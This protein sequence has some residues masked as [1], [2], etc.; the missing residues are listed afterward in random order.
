MARRLTPWLALAACLLATACGPGARYTMR[1]EAYSYIPPEGKS[2]VILPGVMNTRA[3]SPEF[4]AV[5]EPIAKLLVD[6]GYV[7]VQEVDHAD[8]GVYLVFDLDKR[9]DPDGGLFSQD[10]AGASLPGADSQ[11]AMGFVPGQGFAFAR[12][13]DKTLS[14]EAVD[15]A[16]YKA[17]DPKYVLWRVKVVCLRVVDPLPKMMPSIVAALADSIGTSAYTHLEV[18]DRLEVKSVK[19]PK[20]HFPD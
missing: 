14:I 20:H 17:N 15:M 1:V 8:I 11:V 7:R 12:P 9:K 19:P 4:T 16:R 6:K 5:A 3:G 2:F 18:N 13:T 10:E